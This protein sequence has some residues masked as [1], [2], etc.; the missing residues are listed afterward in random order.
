MFVVHFIAYVLIHHDLSAFYPDQ[1]AIFM[2][3]LVNIACSSMFSIFLPVLFINLCLIAHLLQ[4]DLADIFTTRYLG[5]EATAIFNLK[6]IPHICQLK[7]ATLILQI[8]YMSN[9]KI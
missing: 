5:S 1:L 9:N 8:Y 2:K 6:I 3:T 4:R 7:M